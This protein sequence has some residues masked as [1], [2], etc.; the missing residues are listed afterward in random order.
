MSLKTFL[1]NTC[2]IIEITKTIVW[3]EEQ[4]VENI[5]YSDI[6]CYY[7]KSNERN[8]DTWLSEK[9]DL[10]KYRVII[11]PDKTLVKSNM[12]II[13]KDKDLWVI[14]RYNIWKPKMNRLSNWQND[15]IS[16]TIKKI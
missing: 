1:T 15:N 2:D 14:W 9:T 8:N 10:S 7:Y 13:V 3:W 16:F 4:K 6:D 12:E 5:I 11:E